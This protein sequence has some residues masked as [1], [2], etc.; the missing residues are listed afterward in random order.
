MSKYRI[1]IENLSADADWDGSEIECDGFAILADQGKHFGET[2]HKVSNI[3]IAEMI[4]ASNH[5]R[6]AARIGLAM[7]EAMREDERVNN[8]F[9]ALLRVAW[10][11]D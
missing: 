9:A 8:P 5:F 7:Y 10:E 6:A 2:M 11:D 4:A 3:D 1:T